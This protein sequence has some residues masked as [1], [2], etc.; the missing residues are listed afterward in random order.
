MLKSAIQVAEVIWNHPANRGRRLRA[1][2]Q[3]IGWQLY[4]RAVGKPLDIKAFGGTFRCH[5]DSQD[6]G[7]VIYF[8]GL[9]DPHEMAFL[10]HYLRPADK[11]IDAGA[12]VGIYSLF[13]ASLIGPAGRVLAFEPDPT[14]ADRLREN[15]ALNALENVTVRQCAIADFAGTADFTQGADTGN[16]LY[17]VRTYDRPPQ[18]VEVTTL[19]SEI[20]DTRYSLCKMDVEG[21]EW[22]A[23]KGT[24]KSLARKNPPVWLMELSEK[25]QAKTGTTVAEVQA[26]LK[27]QG[28]DLW[29]YDGKKLVPFVLLPRKPGQVGDAVAIASSELDVV[30]ARLDAG[31]R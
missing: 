12:N 2:G 5:R 13:M 20:G 11:V 9:P 10:E 8:N 6:A 30:Q 16:A 17:S 15:V 19:D 3:S 1:L 21:A 31:N 25:L 7:R 24:M 23:L 4:K 29:R 26:W 14:N 18:Q 27:D 22:A 28:Y